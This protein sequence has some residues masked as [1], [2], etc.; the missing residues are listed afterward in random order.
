MTIT[1][2]SVEST[3]PRISRAIGGYTPND[4]GFING[5]NLVVTSALTLYL[6]HAYA[7]V[8][9]TGT[10]VKI[11]KT[12]DLSTYESGIWTGLI[13]NPILSPTFVGDGTKTTALAR[14]MIWL[15]NDQGYPV[16]AA[17]VGQIAKFTTGEHVGVGSTDLNTAVIAGK[18]MAFDARNNTV[19]VDIARKA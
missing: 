1:T 14:P 6:N 7:F 13:T 16:A 15:Q 2:T 4:I 17:N 3:L 11:D 19:L 9:G 10:I 8:P 18:I 12:V 5:G